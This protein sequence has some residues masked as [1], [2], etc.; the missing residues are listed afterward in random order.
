MLQ[1]TRN[2][3]AGV[4]LWM[5]VAGMFATGCGGAQRG[6]AGGREGRSIEV[7]FTGNHTFGRG[8]LMSGLSLDRA[9]RAGRPFDPY[10]VVTDV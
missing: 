6:R 10:L 9:L 8:R 4:V 3:L 2:G 1:G 5:F 7:R